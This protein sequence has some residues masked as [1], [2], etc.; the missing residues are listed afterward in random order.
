MLFRSFV[1]LLPG[2]PA[3]MELPVGLPGAP[4]SLALDPLSSGFLL[5][6]A[7]AGTAAIVFAAEAPATQADPLPAL[8]IALAGLLLAILAADGV[9][10]ALGLATGGGAIWATAGHREPGRPATAPLAVVLLAAAAVIVA[11]GLLAPANASLDFAAIRA[12][13]PDPSRAGWAEFTAV[14]GLGGLLGL[15]PL[16]AWLAPAHRIL[17]VPAAALLSGA[18]L[19]TALY[20]LLRLILDLGHAAAPL[21]GSLPLLLA[22]TAAVLLGGW[23]ACRSPELDG[24]VAWGSLR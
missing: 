17:P 8:S 22:G 14:I 24:A 15:A 5:L 23:Q 4:L 16:H 19:P 3:A 1:L 9:T 7:I 21:A 6:V 10:L 12:A 18:L 20:G 13:P 11:L 2:P